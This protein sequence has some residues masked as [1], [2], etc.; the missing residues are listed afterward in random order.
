MLAQYVGSI[1]LNRSSKIYKCNSVLFPNSAFRVPNSLT[2]PFLPHHQI[3]NHQCG[4]G[5]DN[6]NRPRHHTGIVASFG[7]QYGLIAIEIYCPLRLTNCGGWFKFRVAFKPPATIGQA[8][9]TADFD[10]N[11]A[12]LE[13]K[14]RHDPCVVPRAVPIVEA[15]TALTLGDLLLR[16]RMRPMQ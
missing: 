8:Q 16:Q 7:F 11:E 4:H 10:G 13:A 12:L 1:C 5:L 6:R 15:M 3:D 9:R 2:H 14:G